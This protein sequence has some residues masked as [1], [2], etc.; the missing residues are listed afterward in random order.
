[1]KQGDV[2]KQPNNIERGSQQ[3]K[4]VQEGRFQQV[5]TSARRTDYLEKPGTE[6]NS[7][8]VAPGFVQ[9]GSFRRSRSY[10]AIGQMI[11]PM[12][13]NPQPWTLD[14]KPKPLNPEPSTQRPAQAE[15]SRHQLAAKES[16]QL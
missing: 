13:A 6:K 10:V 12:A 11:L 1:M 7:T 5:K 4:Q 8:L 9:V 15:A 16:W 3:V 14:S 2:T